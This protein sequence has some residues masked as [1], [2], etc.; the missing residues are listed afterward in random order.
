MNFEAIQHIPMS[1]QAHGI[2]PNHVVFRLRAGRD[3]LKH[4]TLFYADRACRL[5]PVVFSSIEMQVEAQDE[6]FDYFQVILESPYKRICYFFELDDGTQKLLY[7][8]DF[9]TDHRVDDRSEYYQLPFNHPADIAAPPAW[10]QDAV[11]YNIFPDSFATG[12]RFISGKSSE[13]EWNG[14]ITRGKLG[15]TLRGVIENLDYIQELGATC[16]YMNPIFAAGEYHKYDLLDY[17]HID[18]CF[19]TDEDF[20]QLVN[21]CHARGMRVIIDGVFNHVGWNFFAFDDAV[22][23]GENSK[24]KNWFYHLQFPVER[25]EDP[26]TYPTYE[27]FGYERMMPKTNTCNPEVCLLYTSDAAD[28]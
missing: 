13:K 24:Y 7:Y 14:Q 23:N 26:E 28:E 16:I 15:G 20:R 4:C 6:W 18:P 25:P 9:F 21:D 5:T 1:Q 11:V 3:D 10:A 19:G 17:H 22:R 8:G 2:D 27:C 12:R